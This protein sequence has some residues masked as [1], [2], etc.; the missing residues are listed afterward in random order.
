M[1]ATDLK[2]FKSTMWDI[3]VPAKQPLYIYSTA[4]KTQHIKMELN[5][6]SLF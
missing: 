1:L 6:H 5:L 4:P 3:I 2:K